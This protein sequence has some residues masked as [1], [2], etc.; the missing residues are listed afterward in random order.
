MMPSETS[1]MP[2]LKI[3]DMLFGK[4][5]DTPLYQEFHYEPIFS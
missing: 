5:N 3:V 2:L 1:C 4:S